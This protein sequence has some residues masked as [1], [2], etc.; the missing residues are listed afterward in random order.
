MTRSGSPTP[1]LL[2][3]A[4]VFVVMWGA[5]VAPHFACGHSGDMT[6]ARV[7]PHESSEVSLEITVDRH[8]NP[9]LQGVNDIAT[10]LGKVLR[11]HLPG[12]RHSMLGDLAKPLFSLSSGY[13]HPSPIPLGHNAFESAPE[14]TT[15]TWTWRPA[16]SPMRVSVDPLSRHT[17]LLWTVAPDDDQPLEGWRILL[18]GDSTPPISLPCPPFSLRWLEQHKTTLILAPSAA[19]LALLLLKKNRLHR[20]APGNSTP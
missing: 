8:Q 19:L 14:L 2:P 1:L 13:E 17:V 5:F 3:I 16:K 15:L 7:R 20:R 10:A 4:I 9:H 6:I 18:A 11:I 12:G